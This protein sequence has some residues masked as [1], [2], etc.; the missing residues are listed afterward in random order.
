METI[1]DRRFKISDLTFELQNSIQNSF[2][3][4]R[5]LQ[6]EIHNHLFSLQ[7]SANNYRSK[8]RKVSRLF[9]H[10]SNNHDIVPDDLSMSI[11]FSPFT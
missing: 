2:N 10:R 7:Y 6:S 1:L 3:K 4:I 9:G 8:P 11:I 5:I